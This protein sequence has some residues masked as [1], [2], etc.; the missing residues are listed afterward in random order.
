MKEQQV[1]SKADAGA[2]KTASLRQAVMKNPAC[3]VQSKVIDEELLKT[4][5]ER[6]RNAIMPHSKLEYS[7]YVKD[8]FSKPKVVFDGEA[9]KAFFQRA[10]IRFMEHRARMEQ[11]AREADMAPTS[12][13]TASP[14]KPNINL[15][16]EL[17]KSSSPAADENFKEK[18]KSDDQ[19]DDDQI[20]PIWI[21]LPCTTSSVVGVVKETNRCVY[22]SQDPFFQ[23]FV[24]PGYIK[25]FCTLALE[26]Y[27]SEKGTNYRYVRPLRAHERG[28]T[29]DRIF[30][31][32]FRASQ[33]DSDS[34]S[35][36]ET[37]ITS[38]STGLRF[39]KG[40][41]MFGNAIQHVSQVL[42]TPQFW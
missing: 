24:V 8:S 3:K 9:R 39:Y 18:H 30:T 37:F 28:K 5:F 27:N 35:D 42:G 22:D 33:S 26:K 10:R 19:I 32:T 36:S 29:H 7:D 31:S 16:I 38:I 17:P 2:S 25:E 15:I 11:R 13:P 20:K 1:E 40:K 12:S 34:D 14:E 41:W 6:L 21:E 23:K 4:H